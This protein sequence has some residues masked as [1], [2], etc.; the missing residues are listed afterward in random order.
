MTEEELTGSEKYFMCMGYLQHV[1]DM[2]KQNNIP[3][4]RHVLAEVSSRLEE[5]FTTNNIEATRLVLNKIARFSCTTSVQEIMK[6]IE[7]EMGF[8]T[9]LVDTRKN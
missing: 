9:G 2:A 6:E 3:V 5:K 7:H 4:G 8:D 1:V